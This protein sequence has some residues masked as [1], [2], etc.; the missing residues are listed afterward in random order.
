MKTLDCFVIMPFAQAFEDVYAA[1]KTGV[2]NAVEGER[3]TC[4]RL[5]EIRTPGRISLDLVK[6]IESATLCIGD[7]TGLNPNVMWEV[8]YGMALK[9]PLLLLSQD[10]VAKL[11]FDIK[12]YRTIQYDR[13]SLNSTLVKPLKQSV[14]ATLGEHTVP[15]EKLESF[16]TAYTAGAIAVTGSMDG[17]RAKCARRIASLL[18]PYT[19]KDCRWLCGSYGLVDEVAIN[20]L[21][22]KGEKVTIVGYDAYDIS[23]PILHLVKTYGL[24][25]IDA[26]REQIPKLVAHPPSE[27]DALFLATADL[28]ILVWNGTST[29]TKDM[30]NWYTA[31]QRDHI[32][33][34]I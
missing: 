9:K 11:P 5:D 18:G 4:K 15:R 3:I 27:R 14:R 19:G 12:D 31:S 6:A 22:S 10:E 2:E 17:D 32:V 30:I 20:Y 25:F 7:V 21:I 23:E 8:G 28:V 34:Y 24:P 26:R 29:G 33:G 13:S 1:I 16:I